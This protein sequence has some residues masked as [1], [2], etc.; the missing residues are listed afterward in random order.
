[1]SNPPTSN[2]DKVVSHLFPH[3]KI[4]RGLIDSSAPYSDPMAWSYIT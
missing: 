2:L 3:T 1:M 4:R